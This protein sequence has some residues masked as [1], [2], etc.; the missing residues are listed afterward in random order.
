MSGGCLVVYRLLKDCCVT[1]MAF[2]DSGAH[3][4]GHGRILSPWPKE[5][6]EQG[7]R[8]TPPQTDGST[9][10]TACRSANFI[11]GKQILSTL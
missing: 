6:Q 3:L 10:L 9:V 2:V 7:I 5:M 8:M 1:R 4:A 11:G